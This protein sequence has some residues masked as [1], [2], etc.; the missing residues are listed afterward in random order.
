[1]PV[2]QV[3]L[4]ADKAGSMNNRVDETMLD[5][6][7]L[8][9]L[10]N[11]YPGSVNGSWSRRPGWLKDNATAMP[12]NHALGIC[13]YRDTAENQHILVVG[14]DG[15]IYHEVNWDV[16]VV[17]HDPVIWDGTYQAVFAEWGDDV[18]IALGAPDGS[19]RNLRY[20]GKLGVVF[21]VG[22]AAP[23]TAPTLADG[24]AG[25][26]GA[27]TVR[28]RV[29]FEHH[30]AIGTVVPSPVGPTAEITI[31]ANH[32]VNLTNIPVA[33]AATHPGRTIWR[34][35]W[36][37][38]DGETW[39]RLATFEDNT[40]T[41]YADNALE[42]TGEVQQVY[43]NLPVCKSV[44]STPDGRVI[45]FND[46]DNE[47]PATYFIAL[48]HDHPEVYGEYD[49]AGTQDDPVTAPYRVRD[50]VMVGKRRSIL[51]LNDQ[52]KTC[53]GFIRG[54]G[55][56]SWAT[57]QNIGSE[58]VWLSERGPCVT[59]H[60]IATDFVFVGPDPHR[61]CLA[62]TWAGVVK[63]RLPY[64]GSAHFADLGIVAWSVQTCPQ[65]TG[66]EDHNDTVICWDYGSRLHGYPGGR[67]GLWD[68]MFDHACTV[69]GEGD[70]ADVVWG[71]FPLGFV[72]PLAHGQ[73]GDGVDSLIEVSVEEVDGEWVLLGNTNLLTGEA[74]TW[75]DSGLVGSVLWVFSGAG[76]Q[77]C[78][79]VVPCA[80]PYALIMEHDIGSGGT[81]RVRTQYPLNID[82]TS[83]VWLGGFLSIVDGY[84]V[85]KEMPWAQKS[86]RHLDVQRKGHTT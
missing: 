16:P 81:N 13:A 53:E 78:T 12:W 83:R 71:A 52:C 80:R 56:V 3:R 62:D 43:Y 46:R 50:G 42:A 70:A 63:E 39:R 59:N 65:A 84:L 68:E 9:E 26:I 64:A 61:F 25:A 49:Y 15:E 55:V 8:R 1:M 82:T 17:V 22:M 14:D 45:W 40:T 7:L 20:D 21:G 51:W 11:A 44:V 41:T 18:F 28:Y 48:D 5:R 4:D 33:T 10:R 19:G 30:P 32:R 66:K 73:H 77:V 74:L 2:M 37:S 6:G 75:A 35:L 60:N 76:S 27:G 54:V 34:K 31:A 47:Q 72:G 38:D 69:L 79:P 86:L 67:V 85:S 24:G 36:R 58:V 29:T 23:A 57:V